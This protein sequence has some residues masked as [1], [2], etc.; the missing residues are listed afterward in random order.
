[1]KYCIS[2]CYSAILH[3]LL[4]LENGSDQG[5]TAQQQ[6]QLRDHLKHYI[7]LMNEV[8]MSEMVQSNGA[9]YREKVRILQ[10]RLFT[11]AKV[12]NVFLFLNIRHS[13]VCVTF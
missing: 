10:T 1:M 12:V 4:Q 6:K 11:I 5:T 7:T 9:I 8:L 3:E 13:I 2:V